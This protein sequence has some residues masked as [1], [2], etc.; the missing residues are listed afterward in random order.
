MKFVLIIVYVLRTGPDAVST[1]VSFPPVRPYV[2]YDACMEDS[3]ARVDAALK[4]HNTDWNTVL[5]YN[6]VPVVE[7]K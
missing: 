5:R 3:K 4:V 2:T 7:S 1:E 6:C